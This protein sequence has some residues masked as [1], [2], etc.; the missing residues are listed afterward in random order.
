M[1]GKPV[2]NIRRASNELVKN[3]IFTILNVRRGI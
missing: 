3:I 1:R 2:P